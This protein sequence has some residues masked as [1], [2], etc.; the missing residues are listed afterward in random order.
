MST[1]GTQQR[2]D[3]WTEILCQITRN[4]NV[5]VSPP[6]KTDDFDPLFGKV[7]GLTGNLAYRVLNNYEKFVHLC[8]PDDRVKTKVEKVWNMWQHIVHFV[9]SNT[10]PTPEFRQLLDNFGN[11][12]I[13]TYEWKILTPYT[14]ILV[15]HCAAV[16]DRFGN[17]PKYSQEGF[18]AA[19]K[20]H[21]KIA[22]RST[23]HSKS[24]SVQQQVLHLYRIIN[25]V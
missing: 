7:L 16:M 17:I 8:K 15:H 5:K 9:D 25:E 10:K 1:T 20:L 13:D 14:H 12:L 4:S 24:K 18:E 3:T 6:K 19:N 23:D 11:G 21:K 22:Q 2:L